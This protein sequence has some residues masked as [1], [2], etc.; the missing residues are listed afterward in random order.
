ME[1]RKVMKRLLSEIKPVTT[2]HDVGLKRVLLAANESGCSLT[3]IAVTD[4]KAG[5]VAQAHIHPDMQEAFY[6][7]SGDLD[8]LLDNELT[9]CHADEFVYV[10]SCVSH[11]LRA[12]TDVRVMTIGCVIEAQRSKLY[13]MLFELN[14]HEVVWGGSKLA[15]WKGLAEMDHI[16]E[17]WEVS[18]VESSP[19][20]IANGTW[21]GYVLPEVI[22]KMPEAIL[23]REV[24]KRY[25]GKLPLLVK[26]LDIRGNLSIQV[27]PDDEM[28]KREHGKMGKTEMWYVLDAEP[29]ACLYSGFK[30][31]LTPE[32]YK[33]KV[34]DGTIVDALARHEAHVGDVFYI[35]SGRVHAACSGVLLAEVQQSSDVT[36]RIFDYNRP[37]LDGKP[38]ELHTELAA[39]ALNYKVENEYRTE[40]SN[41]ENRAN[42]VV[43]SPFFSVRVMELKEPFHRNLI[44]H[45][46]FVITMCLKGDCKLRVRSTQAEVVLREGFSCLIPAAIADYDV[47][48]M[49]GRTRILDAFIDNREPSLAARLTRFLR[50]GMK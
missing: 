14:L 4:L 3:Q 42:R 25:G 29:G 35:P 22:A 36:Y 11:E 12:I 39:K 48:P 10:K 21:A 8:V 33:K 34:E 44:K 1:K 30:Q 40:Y 49:S 19:S 13:P 16:G 20:V 27:H 5:E 17:S 2:S 41:L 32:E 7:M 6:V 28:A 37:G 23:G 47:I 43:D 24:A 38:R 31:E 50:I 46:S 9:H 45:D 15:Q 26:F 18:A